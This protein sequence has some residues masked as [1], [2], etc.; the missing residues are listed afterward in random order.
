MKKS[1]ITERK[2]YTYLMDH[3]G[4]SAP[5][6]A[7]K[8]GITR[9]TVFLYL[10][11][12]IEG[13]K[14]MQTGARSS[15][16]YF[17][18]TRVLSDMSVSPESVVEYIIHQTKMEYGEDILPSHVNEIFNTYF[19]FLDSR[20]RFFIGI[21]GFVLWCQDARHDFSSRIR[22][23][24]YEYFTLVGSIEYRRKKHEFFDAT[25]LARK[26][27]E[28]EMDIGFDVFLFHDVFA[29]PD[30]YGR[31]R[32]ALELAY[33]KQNGD[34][35]LL[36]HAIASSGEAIRNYST[37]HAI[38]AIIYTPPTQGRNIQFRDVLEKSLQMPLEKIRAEKI[39]LPNTILQ[40]QKNI[41]DRR[42]RIQ[43]AR[44]SIMVD[45]PSNLQTLS[46]ILILDDSFTTGATPNAIALKLRE[47]GYKG[48]ITIITIC[49]SFSY[50]LAIMEDEI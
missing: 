10:Q 7:E 46:H 40:A 2:I 48:K 31:T 29:L 30:G 34:K 36:G 47:A 9:I 20:D 44:N 18:D 41:R 45:I 32:I 22:E 19:L 21:E 1:E 27:L 16:R 11:K 49:G 28:D 50:D 33:G 35:T 8:L 38:D 37:K 5:Q 39:H 15:T 13:E 6:I 26:N 3:P 25:E 17:V 43:N 42:L 23:K 24:A 14:V 4:S 12:L